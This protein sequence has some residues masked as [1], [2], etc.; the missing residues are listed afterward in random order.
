[1]GVVLKERW[2]WRRWGCWGR[3]FEDEG[4]EDED[5]PGFVDVIKLR[6]YIRLGV[7]PDWDGRCKFRER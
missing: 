4:G 5:E 6:K 2:W 1:V 3:A 7:R